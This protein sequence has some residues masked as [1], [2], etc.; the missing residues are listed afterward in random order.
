[1][2]LQPTTKRPLA[3]FRLCDV[4]LANLE[5][6]RTAA[7]ELGCAVWFCPH[8]S[9]HGT[10]LMGEL[11][12]RVCASVQE[13]HAIN[14]ELSSFQQQ[15]KSVAAHIQSPMTKRPLAGYQLCGECLADLEAQ[16]TAMGEFGCAVR[17]CPHASTHGI[18]LMGELSY[19]VCASLED[20]DAINEGLS[21]FLAQTK[22][23]GERIRLHQS[24]G[25]LQ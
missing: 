2:T 22:A 24:G 10:W 8:V 6:Q 20:A 16:R 1:M 12:Y 23:F 21:T 25:K 17:F 13:A 15:A 7:G 11:A 4:C 14:Q 5:T 18:W 9:T 19:K 3:N